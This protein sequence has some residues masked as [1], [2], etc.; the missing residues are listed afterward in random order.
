MTLRV[1]YVGTGGKKKP[2]INNNVCVWK[3]FHTIDTT[4]IRRR[5]CKYACGKYNRKKKII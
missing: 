2:N 3:L 1:V 5:D 4:R